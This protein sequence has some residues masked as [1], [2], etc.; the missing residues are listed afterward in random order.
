MSSRRFRSVGSALVLAV[1]LALAAS[2][3]QAAERSTL[4]DNLGAKVQIWL[5]GWLP[6]IRIDSVGATAPSGRAALGGHGRPALGG[7]GRSLTQHQGR[8][9]HPVIRP[10]CDTS[11]GPDPNGCPRP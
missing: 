4:L 3:A 8:T 9:F 10:E 6:G 5:A 2:P 1:L 11:P 7:A